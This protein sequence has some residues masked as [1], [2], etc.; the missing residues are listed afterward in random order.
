MA[1]KKIQINNPLF[2]TSEVD[3]AMDSNSS[4]SSETSYAGPMTKER[5]KVLV[6]VCA[7]TTPIPLSSPIFNTSKT[8]K[9]QTASSTQ[10]ASKDVAGLVKEMLFQPALSKTS[11]PI[12]EFPI[13]KEETSHLMALSSLFQ[14]ICLLTSLGTLLT[15]LIHVLC[16]S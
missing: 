6:E 5:T 13:A 10:G 14:K 9:L 7:Y 11:K 16:Q 3:P 1:L 15:L 2:G 8:Q 4:S 12:K